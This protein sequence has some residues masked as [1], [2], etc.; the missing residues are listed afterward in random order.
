MCSAGADGLP[1]R[2]S[3]E[4]Q[5]AENVAEQVDLAVGGDRA[6]RPRHGQRSLHGRRC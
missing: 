1:S 5:M 6:H 4:L 2:F 3:C